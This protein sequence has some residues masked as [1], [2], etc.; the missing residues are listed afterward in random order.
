VT[1][2]AKDWI[3]VYYYAEQ[4][5]PVL[6]VPVATRTFVFNPSPTE[7][8]KVDFVYYVGKCGGKV[9]LSTHVYVEPQQFVS[10]NANP[11]AQADDV[12]VGGG[13]FRASSPIPVNLWS[14]TIRAD[15]EWGPPGVYE[16][17]TR[18][19]SAEYTPVWPVKPGS[20]QSSS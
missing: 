4:S 13:C 18:Y 3:G 6:K 19:E 14:T 1:E 17:A 9:F 7:A 12:V 2:Y 15:Q 16:A 8:A 10:L 20:E 11:S 5:Q